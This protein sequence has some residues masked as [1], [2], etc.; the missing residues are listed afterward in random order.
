MKVFV[1]GISSKLAMALA[2]ELVHQGHSVWGIARHN[3][4]IVEG[5]S[6][7][8]CD[9]TKPEDVARVGEEM[10]RANFIPDA[11]VLGAGILEHDLIPEFNYELFLRTHTTNCFGA[12]L[13]INWFLPHFKKRGHGV[14]VAILSSQIF[15]PNRLSA[16]Y[17]ASKAALGAA[18]RN[19]R[20]RYAHE[21]IFFTSVYFGP[22]QSKRE[23]NEKNFFVQKPHKVV[24]CI[25]KALS[26]KRAAYYKP[27]FLKPFL[28]LGLLLPDRFM[29]GILEF[30]RR[31]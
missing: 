12:L 23:P 7:S 2:Q 16:G 27:F 26:G 31:E 11:V 29:L 30:L 1:T 10:M 15:H 8:L 28:V 19:L 25:I 9:T 13:W 5:I 4:D 24:P 20:L 14:F 22:I 18:F 17:A 21:N 6:F 3:G